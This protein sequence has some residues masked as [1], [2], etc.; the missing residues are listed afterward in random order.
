MTTAVWPATIPQ[1]PILNAFSEQRRRNIAAFSPPVGRAKL[2]LRSTAASVMT[3][4]A[5]RMTTTQ[6]AAFYTFYETTLKDG[7]LPFDWV[8]PVTGTT[9]TWHFDGREAPKIDRMTPKT[10]RVTFNL[11]RLH[12]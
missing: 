3:S 2:G 6:L 10:H 5:F 1:C 12:T 4:V 7:V 8:H 11:L 9:Y